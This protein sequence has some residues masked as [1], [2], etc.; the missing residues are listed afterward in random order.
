[1]RLLAL[2]TLAAL[3]LVGASWN[4]D[5]I[6]RWVETTGGSIARNADGRIVDVDLSSQ[7]ISDDDLALL[8]RLEHLENLNLAYTWITDQGMEHLKDLENVSELSLYYCDYITDAAVIP[9]KGWKKLEV[10]DLEGADVTSVAFEHIAHLESLRVLRVGHSRVEDE[11]FENL[12]PLEQLEEISFGGNKMSGRALPLLKML[13][14]LRRVNLGGLQRTDSGLW[15]VA[16]SDY[17]LDNLAELTDLTV[18]D[19]HDTKIGD[20]GLER[21]LGLKNLE[22][23]DLSGTLVGD[24]GLPLISKFGELKTVRLWRAENVDDRSMPSIAALP[25][26]ETLD[27]AQTSVTDE[28]LATLLEAP[29]LKRLYLASTDVTK[30]AAERFREQRPD[31]FVSWTPKPPPVEREED[32]AP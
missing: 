25:G 13:P 6:A 9:L 20:R 8:G 14:S 24:L 5:E 7:W 2:L 26:L 17:N 4:E 28:G 16:L 29:A 30:Q 3:P 19:M 21:L 32:V 18:L 1:M 11:G 15:G 10:L 27:L 12:A 22:R 31:V 23:L